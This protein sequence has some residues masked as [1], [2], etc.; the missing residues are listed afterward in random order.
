VTES[1]LAPLRLRSFRLF[2]AGQAL[3]TL[4][5]SITVVALAFAVLQTTG[6]VADVGLALAATRLPLAAFVLLG[7]VAGDRLSRR[8]VMLASDLGRFL[9]QGTAA[10]LLLLGQACFWQLVL[11]FGLN[12]V[13]QAFFNPAGV[14]LVGEL[15]PSELLQPA[16]GLLEFA[17]N[18]SALL[19]QLVGGVLVTLASPGAAFA[20]DS[21]TFLLSAAAL[22]SLRVPGVLV[23]RRVGGILSDLVSG[24]GEFRSR[25]WLLVGVVQI[26]LLNAFALVSFFALGPVVAKRSL[27]GGAAWGIIGAGFALGMMA[28]S[29]LAS[30]WRPARPLLAAFAAVSLASV[31]LALLAQAAPTAAVAI[32][33]AFGGAQASF[34]GVLWTSAMQRDVPATSIARVAAYSQIGSLILTPIGFASVGFVAQR[35]GISATLWAGA[36]WIV[37]STAVVVSLPAIRRYGLAPVNPT[38][39]AN[40]GLGR[41]PVA[42]KE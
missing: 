22:W 36:I 30:R 37:A 6:S 29:A 33:A 15:V 12:G 41:D 39:D 8:N 18:G 1:R 2:F 21:A 19:G 7:G 23:V 34:W 14:G 20:L 24:W 16:N 27:G 10:A 9:T 32:A 31:Q 3:S 11:P 25:T 13:A 4:G 28:G 26:A 5:S 35:I 40:S 17:R 42:V 38:A